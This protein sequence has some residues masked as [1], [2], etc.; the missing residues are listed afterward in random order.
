VATEW[1]VY[2]LQDAG[3]T[4][5]LVELL[6]DD[7]PS[8][9]IR[10]SLALAALGAH[11]A[12]EVLTLLLED[13]HPRVRLGAAKAL[14]RLGWNPRGTP[15]EAAYCAATQRWEDCIRLGR[16]AVP[17]LLEGIMEPWAEHRAS[18]ARTLGSIGVEEARMPLIVLLWDP[19]AEVRLAAV[20]A[21]EPY[22][23]DEVVR[24]LTRL[25]SDDD[26]P[27][28]LATA[29]LLLRLYGSDTL[30]ERTRQRIRACRRWITQPRYA[31]GLVVRDRDPITGEKR[32]RLIQEDFGI[33]LEWPEK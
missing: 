18:A 24:E 33:G 16:L 6:L 1:D 14:D 10:A 8:V 23:D 3:D 27:V 5:R 4:D 17:H 20:E 26:Y 28:R 9:R 32:R 31:D 29:Q 12:I 25:L 7:E 2:R 15:S 11:S 19:D 21:L 22:A 13:D 30:P